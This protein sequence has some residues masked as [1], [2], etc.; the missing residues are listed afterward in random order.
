MAHLAVMDAQTEVT[1]ALVSTG[2]I[3]AYKQK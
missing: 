1:T 3:A 2:I